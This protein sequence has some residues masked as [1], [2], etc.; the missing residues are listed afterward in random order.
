MKTQWKPS[1]QFHQLTGN[2]TRPPHK[3]QLS[4]CLGFWDCGV[5][6]LL[7]QPLLYLT[8]HWLLEFLLYR[9]F[10]FQTFAL[11]KISWQPLVILTHIWRWKLWPFQ[12][13]G[14]NAWFQ[15]LHSLH[16]LTK[17]NVC[18]TLQGHGN[19]WQRKVLPWS[20]LAHIRKGY[21]MVTYCN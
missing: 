10:L 18:F 15:L 17:W 5:H 14:L 6:S 4:F 12:T 2:L 20:K 7:W 21:R 19:Q 9:C 11:T 16:L 8:Q 13:A 3:G 1:P